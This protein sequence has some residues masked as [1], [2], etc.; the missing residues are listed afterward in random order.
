MRHCCF[1][2]EPWRIRPRI[3]QFPP[4]AFARQKATAQ[5]AEYQKC[6]AI[7]QDML[8]LGIRYGQLDP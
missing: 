5:E 2:Y 4:S 8:L 7:R 1:L 6:E 3:C